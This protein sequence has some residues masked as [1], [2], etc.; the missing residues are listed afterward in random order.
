MSAGV[1]RSGSDT[2]LSLQSQG[3]LS[4]IDGGLF[5]SN[6]VDDSFVLVDTNGLAGVHVLR[7]NRIAGI[8][9]AKGRLLISDLRGFDVNYLAVDPT[10]IPPDATLNVATREVRLPGKSGTVLR[11]AVSVSHGALIY[12]RDASGSA[13]PVGSTATLQA[14]RVTVPVGYDGQAYVEG[15]AAHN[16]LTITRATGSPCIVN[17]DY[18]PIPGNIPTLGPLICEDMKR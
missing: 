17:F 15:L 11:F 16:Q 12:L 5:A 3:A 10:D 8:T 13:I 18:Q 14:T 9:D 2:T 1:D 7:E 6:T 4:Y